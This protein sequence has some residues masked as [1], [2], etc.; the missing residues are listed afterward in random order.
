MPGLE[1][2]GEGINICYTIKDAVNPAFAGLNGYFVGGV[3]H[4]CSKNDFSTS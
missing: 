3:P 2:N 4:G 1:S